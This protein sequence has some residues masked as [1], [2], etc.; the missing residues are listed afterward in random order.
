MRW[1]TSLEKVQLDPTG[2]LGLSSFTA[3]AII[4]FQL[5]TK[6]WWGGGGGQ[7]IANADH[8]NPASCAALIFMSLLPCSNGDSRFIPTTTVPAGTISVH[9]YPIPCRS[10]VDVAV[11]CDRMSTCWGLPDVVCPGYNCSVCTCPTDPATH[12]AVKIARFKEIY[13]IPFLTGY[14]SFMLHETMHYI[15]LK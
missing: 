7:H 8:L 15:V 12:N 11:K 6:A 10:D 3:L 5:Y 2:P 9:C 4:E 14:D 1:N 13:I